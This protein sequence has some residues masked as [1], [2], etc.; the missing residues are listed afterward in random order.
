MTTRRLRLGRLLAVAVVLVPLLLLSGCTGDPQDTLTR[1]GIISERITN[2]IQPIF[3]IA[4]V[5]FFVVEGLLVFALIKFRRRKHQTELPKQIHGSNTLEIAWTIAPAL[6]LGLIAIP[7][8]RDIRF[9]ADT[10][11]DPLKIQVTAQQWWWAFQYPAEGIITANDLVIPVGRP[12]E[13][14]LNS[15]DVIHSFWVPKLAGKTDVVPNRNNKMW[16]NAKQPGRYSGQCAEFCALSHAK[17][18]FEVVAL[19]PDDYAAWVANQQAPAVQ[20]TGAALQGAQ[21]FFGNACIACHAIKGTTLD[22]KQAIGTFGPNLTHFAS[23]DRFAG[24]WLA[25]TDDDLREWLRDPPK[26]KPGSKMPNYNLSEEQ[27]TQLI[28]YLQS[29]K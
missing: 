12:V 21:V 28:A 15:A 10:P 25:R 17:M 8:V 26:V 6:L 18:K 9:L 23:R 4:I 24:A 27:I 5:V 29:L 13:V 1:D 22:G 19:A 11:Q 20:P 14:T 16:F 2:L 3:V 7:T